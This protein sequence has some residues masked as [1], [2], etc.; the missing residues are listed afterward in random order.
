MGV[1]GRGERAT[2][3]TRWLRPEQPT[4]PRFL[5]D[6]ARL[7]RQHSPPR[8]GFARVRP[9]PPL[10]SRAGGGSEAARRRR[11]MCECRSPAGREEPEREAS[12]LETFGSGARGRWQAGG[13]LRPSRGAR[14]AKR[15]SSL[16]PLGEAESA[17]R[18]RG[19]ARGLAAEARSGDES[20]AVVGAR[21]AIDIA[22]FS[23]T[24][25]R[26]GC[27]P[28]PARACA[29]SC[30]APLHSASPSGRRREGALPTSTARGRTLAITPPRACAAGRGRRGARLPG[31]TRRCG[32]G[33]G[34][35]RGRRP[36]AR[37]RRSARRRSRR[38]P[39]P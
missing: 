4:T 14:S 18:G 28:Y 5:G 39:R 2:R 32:R 20:D 26:P 23:A 21:A 34:R 19:G 11:S 29:R 3:T 8:S 31:R 12:R 22:H 7:A 1:A 9:S 24:K 6:Q 16:A 25:R 17:G 13:H 30:G 36:R 10:A 37:P 38:C 27:T 15:R 35:R 33:R